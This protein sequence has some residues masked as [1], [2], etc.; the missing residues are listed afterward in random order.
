MTEAKKTETKKTAK[1]VVGVREVWYCPREIEADSEAEALELVSDG[2]GEEIE[3]VYE[4]VEDS[5]SWTVTE[6]R[7]S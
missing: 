3:R 4:G 2:E 1:Y 7:S 6:A 5:D